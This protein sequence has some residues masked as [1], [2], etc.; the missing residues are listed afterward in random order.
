MVINRLNYGIIASKLQSVGIIDKFWS[1]TFTITL[2]DITEIPSHPFSLI[3]STG[4]EPLCIT[5]CRRKVL[6]INS[7]LELTRSL[8]RSLSHVRDRINRLIPNVH[9]YSRNRQS[10]GLIN[11]IG[12]LSSFLFGTACETDVENLKS[13]ISDVENKAQLAF[14]DAENTKTSMSSFIELENQRLENVKTAIMQ[15]SSALSSLQTELLMSN[16]REVMDFH[17]IL[18][19]SGEISK[20]IQLHDDLSTVETGLE[21]LVNGQLSHKLIPEE[22]LS[23]VLEQI[24]A[25]LNSQN[26]TDQKLSLLINTVHD[27]YALP[28]FEYTRSKNKIFIRIQFPLTRHTQMNAYRL[29]S[30]TMPIPGKQNFVSTLKSTPNTVLVNLDTQ[31]VAEINVL[32]SHGMV[33]AHEVTWH[34]ENDNSCI[35]AIITNQPKL[36]H[37]FCDFSASQEE[38]E[39]K[40]VQISKTSFVLTNFSHANISCDKSNEITHD[41]RQCVPCFI[42]LQCN[43]MLTAFQKKPLTIETERCTDQT[44]KDTSV[45]SPI[46]LI[47]LQSLYD[48]SNVTLLANDLFPPNKNI[49]MQPLDFKILSP[50]GDTFLASDIKISYSMKKLADNIKNDSIILHNPTEALLLNYI[51]SHTLSSFYDYLTSWIIWL[52]LIAYIIII[53]L[54]IF[55]RRLFT[56]LNTLTTLLSLSS[57][58]KS[59]A[60]N[61][62]VLT[63][64]T[65]TQSPITL[66]PI[67]INL[68]QSVKI[69]NVIEWFTFILILFIII[70]V[71]YVNFQRIH[72]IHSSVILEFK[73]NNALTYVTFCLLPN[74]SDYF[75][76][77]TPFTELPE[78]KSYFICGKL[79]IPSSNWNIS[80]TIN[81]SSIKVPKRIWLGP[82][83]TRELQAILETKQWQVTTLIARS[84]ELHSTPFN[85]KSV[86]LV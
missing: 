35:Y 71:I 82:K 31:K 30:F 66:P 3:N 60:L 51:S 83:K 50:P 64:P 2:P 8:V 22:Q 47:L 84:H 4:N 23:T 59:Y 55:I 21:A 85:Y 18:I 74:A 28:S 58:P 11:A 39:P 33:H 43:C 16:D 63:T 24:K 80:N 78:I 7:T 38:I 46:N 36:V 48:L 54:I 67:L 41:I 27:I 86:Q 37:Q 49:S 25:N 19:T 9:D 12:K 45:L 65:T 68:A 70:M 69:L 42:D 52:F 13:I 34:T 10:R 1:H 15:Q 76:L 81:N 75:M 29:F 72:N 62:D 14:H 5:D 26:Y 17:S 57:L 44:V 53:F 56:R 73:T 6:L 40:I 20:Y 79:N 77:H 32:P 61:F